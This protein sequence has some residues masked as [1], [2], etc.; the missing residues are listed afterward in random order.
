MRSMPR[1]LIWCLYESKN[2][3][4]FMAL[5]WFF[6]SIIDGELTFVQRICVDPFI[7]LI[8]QIMSKRIHNVG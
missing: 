8:F 2:L 4:V 7:L 5:F 3:V 6:A 1:A